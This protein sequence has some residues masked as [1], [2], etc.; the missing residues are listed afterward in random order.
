MKKKSREWGIDYSNFNKLRY[1]REVD[2]TNDELFRLLD[3]E[4]SPPQIVIGGI[5]TE[6]KGRRG[7]FWFSEQGGLWISLVIPGGLCERNITALNITCGLSCAK[8]CDSFISEMGFREFNITVKWP[9]DIML[10][11]KKLGGLLIEVKS[12]EIKDRKIVLGLGIN[13]NQ[14]RFNKVIS[15]I[16]TSLRLM[17]KRRFSVC[18]LANYI[19]K[20]MDSMIEMIRNGKID[21]LFGEWKDYS[22][23]LGR[24]VEI[25]TV[26]SVKKQ[27]KVIGI[28]DSGELI[29]V[30][31]KGDID[32]IYNGYDL[33]IT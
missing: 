33:K 32:R 30:N 13:V 11:N 15:D 4:E 3:E 8:A 20:E 19:I 23:E 21:Y 24:S 29:L 6:G 12:S 1:L 10:E 27:G 18:N 9:N 22:Y 28:G 14:V 2:S 25:S 31:S 17:F 16:A 5:Q 7:R 26:E